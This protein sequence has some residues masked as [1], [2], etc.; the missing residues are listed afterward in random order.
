M[1]EH[2]RRTLNAFQLVRIIEFVEQLPKTVSSKTRRVEL[3]NLEAERVAAGS[4]EGQYYD[5]DFR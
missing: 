4:D 5:R 3:R 1:F 2:S